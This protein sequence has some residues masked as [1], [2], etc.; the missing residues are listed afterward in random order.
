MEKAFADIDFIITHLDEETSNKIPKCIKDFFK[1]NKD[2]NYQSKISL[3]KP[4][5]EQEL[6]PETEKLI[7][8]ITYGYIYD[9]IEKKE[10]IKKIR[11]NEKN[12]LF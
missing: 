3:S 12:N 4:L 9:D 5:F 2:K 8:F 1:K 7:A 10:F 6:S 11:F